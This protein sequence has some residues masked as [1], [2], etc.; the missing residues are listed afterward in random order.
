M[1]YHLKYL[2][3]DKP[4]T[5]GCTVINQAGEVIPY[6][7]KAGW[8]DSYKASVRVAEP[9]LVAYLYNEMKVIGRPSQFAPWLKPGMSVKA[10][11]CELSLI[12]PIGNGIEEVWHIKCPTCGVIH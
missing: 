4:L 1:L 6:E 8:S 9:F 3:V 7:E 5:D 12:N 10:V 2:A 11:D